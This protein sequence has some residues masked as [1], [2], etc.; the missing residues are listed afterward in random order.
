MFPRVERVM[1][2]RSPGTSLIFRCRGFSWGEGWIL[3]AAPKT[4]SDAAQEPPSIAIGDSAVDNSEDII[5]VSQHSRQGLSL[6]ER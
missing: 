4:I 2:A 1:L 3:H 6:K 5:P